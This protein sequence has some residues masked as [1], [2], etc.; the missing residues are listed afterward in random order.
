MLVSRP[1]AYDAGVESRTVILDAEAQP[2]G[3][4]SGQRH[5]DRRAA[6]ILGAVLEGL[7]A[8]EI[9]GR[10]YLGCEPLVRS[11]S[12]ELES[13]CRKNTPQV[14]L[15]RCDHASVDQGWRKDA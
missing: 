6:R 8:A 9:H 14:T 10:F 5:A 12:I 15:Q 3:F 2:I 4:R 13:G 7:Q 11:K 1:T